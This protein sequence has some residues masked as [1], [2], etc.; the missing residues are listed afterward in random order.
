QLAGAA[1]VA[2]PGC[3]ATAAQLALYPLRSLAASDPMLAPALFAVTGSSG[4]GVRPRATTHHPARAHHMF[5]SSVLSHRHEAEVTAA[6]RDWTGHADGQARLMVHAGP[7]VRGIHLTLHARLAAPVG[8]VS[9][10]CREAYA[11]RP[12]VRVLDRPPELCH[13]V[14]SNYALMHAAASEDGR[15]IQ[16]TLV[17]D[18]LIKCACCQG[19]QAMNLA[20]RH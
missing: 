11:G 4:A 2:A 19:L 15:E 1:A 6:W 7:F 10:L 12:F 18:N 20:L 5:A 17:L 13:V 9:A 16:I 8:D 14:G 3:F